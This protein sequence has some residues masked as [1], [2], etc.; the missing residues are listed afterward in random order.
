MKDSQTAPSNV[1]FSQSH[2]D[3]QVSS[4]SRRVSH[5]GITKETGREVQH[6]LS[7]RSIQSAVPLTLATATKAGGGPK[8]GSGQSGSY[9]SG[10]P[11]VAV[12]GA[13]AARLK[14]AD[15]SKVTI[16]PEVA[17]AQL[18]H[19]A[20]VTEVHFARYHGTVAKAQEQLLISQGL[21]PALLD[22]DPAHLQ[23]IFDAELDGLQ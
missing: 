17:E 11:A 5:S 23:E 4:R 8:E 18:Q 22:Y 9:T 6:V 16:P 20:A 7:N 2:F 19:L 13:A 10:R 14:A 1:S 3:K 12:T 15:W 21:D